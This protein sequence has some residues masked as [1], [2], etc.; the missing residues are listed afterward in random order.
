MKQLTPYDKSIAVEALKYGVQNTAR[1]NMRT[2]SYVRLCAE[3]LQQQLPIQLGR[4]EKFVH[5]GELH[6]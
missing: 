5:F 2:P 3:T 6:E 1:R 4:L